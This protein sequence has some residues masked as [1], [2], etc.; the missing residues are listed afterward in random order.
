MLDFI[1]KRYALDEGSMGVGRNGQHNTV[2]SSAINVAC[3][4]TIN[5]TDR[6]SCVGVSSSESGITGYHSK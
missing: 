2:T 6:E 1:E 3:R 4:N 5:P